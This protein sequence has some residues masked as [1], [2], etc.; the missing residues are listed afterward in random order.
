MAMPEPAILT[1]AEMEKFSPNE[2]A[3]AVRE[4]MVTDLT[5]ADP[6]LVAWA[7]EQAKAI[8]DARK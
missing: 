2:R 7:R 6:A 5:Q 8:L 1:A 4:R 3:A